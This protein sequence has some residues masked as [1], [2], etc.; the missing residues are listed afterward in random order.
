M[1]AVVLFDLRFVP[2]RSV[3]R[4]ETS[5][6]GLVR[7]RAF[8]EKYEPVPFAARLPVAGFAYE[9]DPAAVFGAK[10]TDTVCKFAP[11]G[12]AA[13]KVRPWLPVS[14]SAS[15]IPLSNRVE[16]GPRLPL[17]VGPVA[18][19]LRW[20]LARPYIFWDEVQNKLSSKASLTLGEIS[21][22]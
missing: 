16:I 12:R 11:P 18:V 1:A 4:W 22:I 20:V 14:S 6:V 2:H 19:S 5:L 10:V 17:N 3:P 13:R 9:G 21:G 7:L 15:G 8:A